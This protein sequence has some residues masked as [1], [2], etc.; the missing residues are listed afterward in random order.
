MGVIGLRPGCRDV[1]CADR[2]KIEN[3]R[4]VLGCR[5]V[6]L[7]F[8]RVLLGCEALEESRGHHAGAEGARW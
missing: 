7:A 4:P 6:G 3:A 1:V 5:C 8:D 2:L